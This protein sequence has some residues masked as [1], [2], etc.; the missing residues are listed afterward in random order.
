MVVLL[1]SLQQMDDL[2]QREPPI[3]DQ[4]VINIIVVFGV[5]VKSTRGPRS[6]PAVTGDLSTVVRVSKLHFPYGL[7]DNAGFDARYLQDAKCIARVLQVV[8]SD[9]A[10]ACG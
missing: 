10:G 2:A 9:V 6:I 5:V 1:V 7:R 8:E 4:G 3:A